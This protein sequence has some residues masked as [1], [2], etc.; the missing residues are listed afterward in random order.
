[1]AKDKVYILYQNMFWN[2]AKFI[3]NDKIT[4]GSIF[5]NSALLLKIFVCM[6]KWNRIMDSY[7]L[8]LIAQNATLVNSMIAKIL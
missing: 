1:M 2:K 5:E 8:S 3:K 6:L 7:E 4:Y